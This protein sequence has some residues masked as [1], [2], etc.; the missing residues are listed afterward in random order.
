MDLPDFPDTRVYAPATCSGNAWVELPV[1]GRQCLLPFLHLS[2][3]TTRPTLADFNKHITSQADI[4]SKEVREAGWRRFEL[5]CITDTNNRAWV[6]VDERTSLLWLM[7]YAPH[8]RIQRAFADV[9]EC[10]L[11][12]S[13]SAKEDLALAVKVTTLLQSL[14]TKLW[15]TCQQGILF[16][17]WV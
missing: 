5:H 13:Q 6:V 15:S 14:N 9:C 1:Y 8:D 12:D 2:L 11:A 3:L 7:L 16:T 10:L 17:V 4:F